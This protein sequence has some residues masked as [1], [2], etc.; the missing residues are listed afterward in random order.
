[1]RLFI[2]LLFPREIKDKIYNYLEE[3]KALSAN[4]NFTDFNNLHLTILYLGETDKPMF[5]KIKMKLS[6]VIIHQFTYQTGKINCFKKHKTKKIVYLEVKNNYS[7]KSLYNQVYIKLKEL[8]LDFPTEKYTPHITLGRQVSISD[9]Q[10]LYEI[11][12]KPLA[13]KATKISLMES[14][15]INGKLTYIERDY[16]ELK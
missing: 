9:I 1:M 7:L 12:T 8:G 11:N 6:E 14:T 16:I 15:R 13:I 10:N 4:G 3:V 2:A 5:D